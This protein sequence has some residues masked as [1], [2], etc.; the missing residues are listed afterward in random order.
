M[1]RN[2]KYAIHMVY[3]VG[4]LVFS[5]CASIGVNK[6]ASFEPEMVPE[7]FFNGPMSAHGIVKNRKGE[8]IRYFNADIMGSIQGD[9]IILDEEFIFND[10]EKQKRVWKIKKL[11]NGT[12]SATAGDVVN[13]GLG[14]VSG[15]SMF[16]KYVLAVPYKGKTINI[17]I[18][19]RMYLVKP[20]I[21]INESIMTKFGFKVGQIILVIKKNDH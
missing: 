17:T 7:T 15:N 13:E 20:N 4:I 8:V 3:F 12:Y 9:T 11:P 2:V 6:Y 19:D 16:L 18:D 1:K 10:G 21:L 14:E 5:G